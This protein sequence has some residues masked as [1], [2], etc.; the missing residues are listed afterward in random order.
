[1]AHMAYPSSGT[2]DSQGPCPSSHPVRVPQI[3]FETIFATEDYA[4]QWPS[5]NQ[6]PFIWSYGDT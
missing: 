2:F 3:L 1:M 6:Q 4:N 5:N